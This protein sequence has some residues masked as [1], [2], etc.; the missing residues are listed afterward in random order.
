MDPGNHPA[1]YPSETYADEY[2]RDLEEDQ[3]AAREANSADIEAD[4]EEHVRIVDG[5]AFTETPAILKT[6]D[7]ID[8][9][10]EADDATRKPS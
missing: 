3:I 2:L 6:S 7:T 4:V 8:D 5:L 10:P 1:G 9:E